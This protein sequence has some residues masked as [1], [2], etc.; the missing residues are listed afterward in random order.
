MLIANSH[1]QLQPHGKESRPY[2]GRVLT[3][4]YV[5]LLS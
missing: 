5:R 4:E 3:S 1:D 2:C